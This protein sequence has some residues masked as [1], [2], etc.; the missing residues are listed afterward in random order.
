MKAEILS[1]GT[2]L[3]LGQITDTNAPYLAQHLSALGIDNYYISQVGDNLGRLVDALR[4]AWE[5]SDLIVI[6]GGL[7]PTE[8]DL[9]REAVA[10]L[11]GE[12]MVVQ[13]ELEAHLRAFFA[14]R[15]I[16]MPERNLKQATLIP[17]A[18]AIPNPIGTAPGWWVEKDGHIL[19]CMPGVPVEMKKMWEEQVVPRLQQRAGGQ[20]ILSRT[21]KIWGLGES[22]VEHLVAEHIRSTNPTLATYAK[23]DGIHLRLTAKAAS[24][25]EAEA[26]IA[27]FE[28]KLR[29]IVG[30]HIYG[31]D[32]ETLAGVTG[33]LLREQGLWAAAMESVSGGLLA[34]LITDAPG[35]SACFR[36][37]IVAYDPSIKIASGVPAATI[38]RHGVVSAET[39]LAMA[40]AARQRL[41]A[42]IGLATTGVAGP[43]SLE[44]HPPGTVHVAIDD[45]GRTYVESTRYSTT[46]SEVKRRA[47]MTAL[48]LLWRAARGAEQKP[49]R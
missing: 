38:E 15:G 27:S 37:G 41:D 36:G 33:R 3:L 6:T 2:E 25:A 14:R 30:D 43:D 24:R 13:P 11:L 29:A 9:T 49:W 8:D 23:P 7:G 5:R 19:V 48:Y 10:E 34:S 31:V 17:S 45:R 28:P 35:S 18:R 1:V 39:A 46:R 42:D 12:E 32:D 21:L 26:L 47:A 4:R 22:T 44:G 20:I 40:R 16:P